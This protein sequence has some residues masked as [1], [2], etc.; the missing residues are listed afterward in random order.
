MPHLFEPYTLKG[1]T[2]RNRIVV[3]PMCQYSAEEGVPNDW[4]QAH[5]TALARGGA[6]LVV[7]EATGVSPEGRITPGCTGLWNDTQKDAFKPVV[8]AIKAAGAVP[9]IQIG[10]AG[11]KASANRPWEGDD[12]IAEGDPRGWQTIAP[13][14][15]AFGGGLSKTPKEMTLEDIARVQADFVAAAE[16]AREA[17]FEW[18]MLHFAHGYLAQN[19]FSKYSNQ[20]TDA[21]GGSAGNRGRFLVETVRA[22]RKAWPAHLPLSARFSVIEFDGDD[23]TMQQEAAELARAM[24]AEGLDF[25]DVSVGFNT[26][27]AKIPWGPGFMGETAG[28]MRRETGLPTATSWY[29]GTPQMAEAMLEKGQVDLVMMGRPLLENPHW[30]FFAAKQLGVEKPSWTL[31]APY[32]HWLERY[33]AA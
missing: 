6:G 31:P 29:V 8:A 3:S 21:Y 11:R 14:A 33:R 16:R 23:E 25:F 32:A 26:P 17:G 27:T 4:H 5:Y 12:H 20:R 22:V 7:V 9:G 2:L 15:V 30:P 18:L 10:H 13:S 1:V 24:K 19:F 28:R